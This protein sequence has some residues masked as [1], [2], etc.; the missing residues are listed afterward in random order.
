VATQAVSAD[1]SA[2]ITLDVGLQSLRWGRRLVGS[3]LV[4]ATSAW[5][6]F[7]FGPLDCPPRTLR[8]LP[9]PA[10]FDA[11]A[12]TPHP[13][14]L[15]GL[16][17]SRR[18][19]DGSEFAS[20]RAF[21]H[22]DRL[23]RIHWP[24]SLRTGELHVTSTWADQDSNVMLMVDALNDLGQSEGLGRSASSLDVTVRAAAAMAVTV[25]AAAAMAEHYL[26]RG[27]RV[28]LRVF[29]T[30]NVARLPAVAGRSHLRRVLDTL[31]NIEAG[32][33]RQ[34]N[35]TTVAGGL[36]DGTLVIVL[37]PLVSPD[38]LTHAVTLARRGLGV[39]IIDTLP[40]QVGRQDVAGTH[41]DADARAQ[42]AW[43]IR[44]L[45]REREIRR[46][47]QAGI[48]TVPWRGPGSLDQV[49]R[50]LGRRSSAGRMARR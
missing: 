2:V 12:P 18:A 29:G 17:R 32:T 28:G 35:P 31:A 3:G 1:S 9:L 19:G 7:R 21:Q 41:G 42:L 40:E 5:G 4:A 47:Q 38:A 6:A 23:R 49:L 10:T 50:D 27:D 43:R 13:N 36:P 39:I 45:E 16:N 22:G 26:R 8:T 34:S 24:L 15:V 11:Q 37:S 14:G 20:I 44:L 33:D 30:I 48:P 46:V 25:R